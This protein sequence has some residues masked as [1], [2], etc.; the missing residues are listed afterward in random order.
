MSR[1]LVVISFKY[2]PENLLKVPK[3]ID[4]LRSEAVSGLH[5]ATVKLN[6][7]NLSSPSAESDVAT[8]IYS[9]CAA[10]EEAL[11]FF[12]KV[13]GEGFELPIHLLHTQAKIEQVIEILSG[14]EIPARVIESHHARMRNREERW[15]GTG[16]RGLD[17][18]APRNR[19]VLRMLEEIE[20]IQSS[21]KMEVCGGEG[22]PES[23]R[24]AFKAELHQRVRQIISLPPLTS[25]TALAYHKVG[26]EMLKDAAKTRCTANFANHPAFQRDGEFYGLVNT[27]KSFAGALGEAWKSVAKAAARGQKV[28]KV[29]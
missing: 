6:E 18:A 13:N 15:R 8:V 24:E 25:A 2:R 3:N 22:L 28:V 29:S 20:N 27:A 19:L 26:M 5:L 1:S 4:E 12:T 21:W 14:Q 7:L 11:A 16:K 9:T 17:V 10:F 23:E